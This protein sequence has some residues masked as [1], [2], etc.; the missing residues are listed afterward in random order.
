MFTT[1]RIFFVSFFK[2][3]DQLLNYLKFDKASALSV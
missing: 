3:S 1:P 2:A